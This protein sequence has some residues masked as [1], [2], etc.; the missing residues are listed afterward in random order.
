MIIGATHI[1]F[2][3]LQVRRQKIDLIF[4]RNEGKGTREGIVDGKEKQ[5][6]F[7]LNVLYSPQM[8]LFLC[9]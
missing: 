8:F 7:F 3:T 9:E 1:M 2:I 6:V 4:Y 5:E